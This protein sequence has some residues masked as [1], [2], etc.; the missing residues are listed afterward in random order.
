MRATRRRVHSPTVVC[1]VFAVQQAAVAGVGGV[2]AP[3]TAPHGRGEAGQA[4]GTLIPIGAAAPA[5]LAACTRQRAKV[6][7]QGLCRSAH[8]VVG[9]RLPRGRG[10]GAAEGAFTRKVAAK[11]GSASV[12]HCARLALGGQ[13]L[14]YAV[15]AAKLVGVGAEVRACQRERTRLARNGERVAHCRGEVATKAGGAVHAV[16]ARLALPGVLNTHPVFAEQPGGTHVVAAAVLAMRFLRGAT[17]SFEK[18][19]IR[20]RD[21]SKQADKKGHTRLPHRWQNHSG[22]DERPFDLR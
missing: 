13:G 12:V 20:Q 19:R 8:G 22:D 11:A 16:A 17:G 9:A 18:P 7:V 10:G 3:P 2:L 6:T 14:A 1:G 15:D 21:E 4:G 5:P